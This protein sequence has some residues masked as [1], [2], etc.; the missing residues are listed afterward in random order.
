MRRPLLA[1]IGLPAALIG[2][3]GDPDIV[4]EQWN[5]T[6]DRVEIE[7]GIED[8]LDP[9]ETSLMSSTGEVEVGYALVSPGGGPIGTDHEIVVEV[10]DEHQDV[11]DR[12]SVRTASPERGQDEYDLDQDSADEG[13]YKTILTSV[14][15]QG[16]ARTD[17]FTFRLWE[18]IEP[19]PEDE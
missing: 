15:V 6:G 17:V 14:G 8:E 12:V 1:M 10:Y 4:Y 18:A 3:G 16:E 2:C 9:V 19:P 13:V 7:V 11:I 5:G